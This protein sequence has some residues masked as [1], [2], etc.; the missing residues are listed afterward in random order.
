MRAP[1]CLL[2]LGLAACGDEPDDSGRTATPCVA[3][4]SFDVDGVPVSLGT[5][6]LQIVA[7]TTNLTDGG[8]QPFTVDTCGWTYG[9]SLLNIFQTGADDIATGWDEEHVLPSTRSTEG[10]A[11]TPPSDHLELAMTHVGSIGELTGNDTTLFDVTDADELTFAVRV[12]DADLA[13]AH[14]WVWGHDPDA[15]F[16]GDVPSNNPSGHTET[17]ELSATSCQVVTP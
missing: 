9:D 11:A 3:G 6:G 5:D 12:Y 15:L 8:F 16:S 10:D 2:L 7:A 13:L 1:S 17:P 4:E 14:C